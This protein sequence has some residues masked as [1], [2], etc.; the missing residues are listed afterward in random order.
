MEIIPTW[1]VAHRV[2]SIGMCGNATAV[3]RIKYLIYR[4]HHARGNAVSHQ[5]LRLLFDGRALTVGV[6]RTTKHSQLRAVSAVGQ[7]ARLL[8]LQN[9][10][11]IA[12]FVTTS[13]IPM[14]WNF[15]VL[16]SASDVIGKRNQPMF[17]NLPAR[18]I[19]I[20][21]RQPT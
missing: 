8:P 5:S 2:T 4:A 19:A 16:C 13:I 20:H 21:V 6:L 9:G 3:A 12:K 15:Q 1:Y 18:G 14:T 7:R 10:F 11:G 17:R